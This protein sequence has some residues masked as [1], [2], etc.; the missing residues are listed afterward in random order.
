M[1]STGILD[2]I[3]DRHEISSRSLSSL[4]L[5]EPAVVGTAEELGLL[6]GEK[7][8]LNFEPSRVDEARLLITKSS[9]EATDSSTAGGTTLNR[10]E[11][12]RWNLTDLFQGLPYAMLRNGTALTILPGP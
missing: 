5:Y 9:P 8:P 10:F 1:L 4:L 2:L 7:I 6:H 11:R 3:G 12:F